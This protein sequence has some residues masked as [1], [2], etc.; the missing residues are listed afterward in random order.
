M[1]WLFYRGNVHR[2]IVGSVTRA[3]YDCRPRSFVMVQD[4]DVGQLLRMPKAHCGCGHMFQR[5]SPRN[6]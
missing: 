5:R 3:V 4:P 2:S 6:A 1:T